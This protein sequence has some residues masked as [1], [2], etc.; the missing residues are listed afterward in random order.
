M[1]VNTYSLNFFDQI[2]VFYLIHRFNPDDK[3]V[4]FFICDLVLFVR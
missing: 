3:I 1:V 4:C 2:S